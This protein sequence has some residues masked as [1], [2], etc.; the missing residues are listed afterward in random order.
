MA[1]RQNFSQ[2]QSRARRGQ[3]GRVRRQRRVTAGT[4][5]GAGT[6]SANGGTGNGFGLTGGGGGGGGRIALQYGVNLF[7]GTT[8]SQ[9]GSG[10]AWA[11]RARFTPSPTANPMARCWRI[12]ADIREPTRLLAPYPWEPLTS[13]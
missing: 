8:T 9:G 12:T 1:G 4:L 7:F 2:W 5:T 11:A 6:I 13:R 3:R 10:S